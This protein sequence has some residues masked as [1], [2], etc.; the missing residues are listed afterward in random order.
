MSSFSF[1]QWILTQL[2]CIFLQLIITISHYGPNAFILIL[3]LP[4][5]AK[6]KESVCA[7]YLASH[8]IF[9]DISGLTNFHGGALRNIMT[10]LVLF[11]NH[12]Q[13]KYSAQRLR[14]NGKVANSSMPIHFAKNKNI[15]FSLVKRT[16]MQNAIQTYSRKSMQTKLK[17]KFNETHLL[18]QPPRDLT[19]HQC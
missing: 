17:V 19:K 14:V 7:H 3:I 13:R 6:P 4:R 11:Y 10:T 9:H 12:T 8:I 1:C 18:K 2:C 5:H 15:R 16:C